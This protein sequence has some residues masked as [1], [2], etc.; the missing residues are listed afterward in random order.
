MNIG[1][2]L[3]LVDVHM[4]MRAGRG[5]HKYSLVVVRGGVLLFVYQTVFNFNAVFL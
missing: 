5:F 2:A 1:N 4:H 3:L